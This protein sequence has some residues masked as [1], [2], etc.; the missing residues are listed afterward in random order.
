MTEPD[1]RCPEC[2]GPVNVWADNSDGLTVNFRCLNFDC[3]SGKGPWD[4]PPPPLP[5]QVLRLPKVQT[6]ATLR[7]MKRVQ[8][9]LNMR[10]GLARK[11]GD[12]RKESELIR[13]RNS[14]KRARKT[15]L[16]KEQ[17]T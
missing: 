1:N 2:N 16:Q 15:F 7:T 9:T 17:I 12:K 14:L 6:H 11:A 13:M 10:I 5:G 3:P 8:N 4:T